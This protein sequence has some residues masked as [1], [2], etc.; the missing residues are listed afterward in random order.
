[1][2]HMYGLLTCVIYS[3]RTEIGRYTGSSLG[4]DPPSKKKELF[5]RNSRFI[6]LRR[7]QAEDGVEHLDEELPIMAYSMFRF[8]M[9]NG[10]CVLYWYCC[11]FF[12][13]FI[14]GH[15]SFTV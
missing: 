2:Q 12:S 15:Y 11:L 3:C 7:S 5:H 1:M 9:E 14:M 13:N 4:W 8:E 6:L 10:K